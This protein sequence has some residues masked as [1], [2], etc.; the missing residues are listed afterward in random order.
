MKKYLL[1]FLAITALVLVEVSGAF[2]D[3]SNAAIVVKSDGGCFWFAGGLYAEGSPVNV[4]TQNGQWTLSC[5]ADSYAGG[6]LSEALVYRSS[7]TAPRG[8]CSTP[9]G[10]TTKFIIVFT[11]GGETHIT[12]Q[13]VSSSYP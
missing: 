2:A 10:V 3:S 12:C 1:I 11:P 6:V 9:A 7:P 5:K 13:G 4:T 8:S